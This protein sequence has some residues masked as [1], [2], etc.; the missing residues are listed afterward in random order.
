MLPIRIHE[1]DPQ[2]KRIVEAELGPLRAID[3]TYQSAGVNRPLRPK[4][5]ETAK[6]GSQNVYRDQVNKTANAIKEI[7]A[8][9]HGRESAMAKVGKSESKNTIASSFIESPKRKKGNFDFPEQER[10]LCSF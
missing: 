2:D 10:F 3:F 8:G 4:D 6:G 7:I 5:D 1:L 9:I